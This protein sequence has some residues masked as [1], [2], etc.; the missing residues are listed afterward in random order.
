MLTFHHKRITPLKQ[1]RGNNTILS[2]LIKITPVYKKLKT[3]LPCIVSVYYILVS[4][5][6]VKKKHGSVLP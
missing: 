1:T 6:V 5:I 2:S 4:S 3:E